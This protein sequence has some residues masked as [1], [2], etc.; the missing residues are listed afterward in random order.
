[1]RM[2]TVLVGIGAFIAGMK[3]ERLLVRSELRDIQSNHVSLRKE[4]ENAKKLNNQIV[5]NFSEICRVYNAMNGIDT[6]DK[7]TKMD[8]WLLSLWLN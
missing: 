6:N 8:E 7:F 5:C 4:C 1:M 3:V 2:V